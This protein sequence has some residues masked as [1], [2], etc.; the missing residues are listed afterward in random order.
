MEVA[1]TD[2]SSVQLA[3]AVVTRKSGESDAYAA[4]KREVLLCGP[5]SDYYCTGCVKKSVK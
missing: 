3:Q 2:G 5:P 1:I 4:C